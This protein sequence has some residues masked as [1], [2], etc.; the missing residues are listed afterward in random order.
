[1]LAP[2]PEL[3]RT[4]LWLYHAEGLTFDAIHKLTGFERREVRALWKRGLKA[5]RDSLDGLGGIGA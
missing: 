4:I 2:L 3:E 5:L 1:M